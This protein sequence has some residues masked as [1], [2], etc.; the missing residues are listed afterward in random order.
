ML[1]LLNLYL[2]IQHLENW[3]KHRPACYSTHVWSSVYFEVPMVTPSCLNEHIIKILMEKVNHKCISNFSPPKNSLEASN[4]DLFPLRIQSVKL[5]G[6]Y[7]LSILQSVIFRLYNVPNG[8]SWDLFKENIFRIFLSS[9]LLL[10]TNWQRSEF[11]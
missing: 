7:V 10:L 1:I 3:S 9:Q 2:T 5:H 6:L 8:Q 4:S 11:H